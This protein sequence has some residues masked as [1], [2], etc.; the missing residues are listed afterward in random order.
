MPRLFV[1]NLR[2]V[3]MLLVLL[4]LLPPLCLSLYTNI[5]QREMGVLELQMDTVRFTRFAA[6]NQEQLIERSRQLVISMAHM[7]EVRSR[8]SVSC[9]R[10]IANLVQLFPRYAVF[11]VVDG[12]GSLLCVSDS[13]MQWLSVA[14]H[15]WLKRALEEGDFTV[16]THEPGNVTSKPLLYFAYPIKS[17]NGEVRGAVFAGLE[18]ATI[19]LHEEDLELSRWGTIVMTDQAGIILACYP[20][21][22]KWQGR[23]LPES[24]VIGA[25]LEQREGTR[26][27]RDEDGINRL[28]AFS[29]VSNTMD[30][31]LFVTI[32]VPVF[33]GHAKAHSLLVRNLT[34]LGVAAVLSL[35]AA[36]S[37]GKHFILKR[38]GGILD[39]AQRLASGD[40]SARC[41]SG[42]TTGELGLLA[43]GFDEM[44]ESLQQRTRELGNAEARYRNLVER[45]PAVTYIASVDEF[46]SAT[47]VS[48]QIEPM[49]GY[50]AEEW[51]A[52]PQ[53]RYKRLHPEDRDRV[54]TEVQSVCGKLQGSS[55]H[56]EYRILARSDRVVWVGDEAVIERDEEGLPQFIRGVMHD[57][58]E[59]RTA[60]EKL[61]AYQKE[62]RSLASQL[63]LAEERER[64]RIATDVHDLIGQKLAMCKIKLE[65]ARQS[66]RTV[67]CT[68]MLEPIRELMEQAIEDSRSLVY[69]ISS[70]I[71]YEFGFEAAVE[72]LAEEFQRQ[73]GMA[74]HCEFKGDTNPL[75]EDVRVLLYQALNEL[76]VNVTKHA[77]AKSVRIKASNE[78]ECIIISVW[79]DGVGL[80]TS[81]I[82]PHQSKT[83][84]F[85]L[86]SIRERLNPLGGSLEILSE[87][88]RG[89][90]VNL[91]APLKKYLAPPEELCT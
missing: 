30:T 4:A 7:P 2:T 89:T 20:E 69:K 41:G 78:G 84:G 3:I 6:S 43:R 13:R 44:A 50:T 25:M 86:F 5:E 85:G 87:P 42:N 48:P 28:F 11:G 90:C 21:Q 9:S 45:I 91:R 76:L 75:D 33:E 51:M 57:I 59:R 12:D 36:W 49:L 77:H 67:E 32:S 35:L 18:L 73:H 8:D 58:T 40:L 10:L 22:E 29:P 16:G 72:W 66:L 17:G 62:L 55:L 24:A 19:N 53:L 15:P 27:E 46:T 61:M 34:G 26:Y 54:M 81:K 39:V 82:G 56:S 88:N 38:V 23:Q 31:G 65:I 79:D 71:L 68:R 70:P 83:G 60:E 63:S 1:T 64:R 52:E 47:Y 74:C 14:D 80:D 37:V